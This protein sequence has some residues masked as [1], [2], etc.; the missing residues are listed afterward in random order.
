VSGNFFQDSV[1]ESRLGLEQCSCPCK[2][3]I[4]VC[5]AKQD[6]IGVVDVN[7]DDPTEWPVALNSAIRDHIVLRGIRAKI[8]NEF[9]YPRDYNNHCFSNLMYYRKTANG[10]SYLRTWLVY[11]ESSNKTFC[12]CCELFSSSQPKYSLESDGNCNWKHLH[13]YLRGH[14]NSPQHLENYFQRFDMCKRL[15]AGNAIDQELQHAIVKERNYCKLV[16][17]SLCSIV[18][19]LSKKQ[20]SIS[21]Q[22]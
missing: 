3:E 2:T 10:E 16:L 22:R 7:Y 6:L 14:E 20:F 11:S 18:L 1:T 9:I 12:I 19:Y 5:T 15:A 8:N 17:Y 21:G 4:S 13:E